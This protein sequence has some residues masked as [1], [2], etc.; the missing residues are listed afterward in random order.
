[1]QI[2]NVEYFVTLAREKH[3]RRAAEACGVSQPTLS[4][5]IGALEAS[6]GIRLVARERRFVGLTPEGEAA[7]PW[8][9]QL[10]ADYDGL[11]R[12][13][14]QPGVGLRGRLRLGA[15]PA[16]MP[17]VGAI[18]PVLA[19]EHPDLRL[20]ILSMNSRQIER[21]LGARDIDG[22]LTYLENEPLSDVISSTFYEEHYHF[23][24]PAAGPF[25][26]R[27]SVTWAEAAI[28]PLCLLT[29]DMQNRRILDAQM[30]RVGVEAA[31]RASANSYA[32]LFS[33]VRHGGLSSILSHVQARAVADDPDIL[34]L[35][36]ADPAPPQ[37]VGLVVPDR[38]PM[39]LKSR[40]ILTCVRS[41]AFRQT[42]NSFRERD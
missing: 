13:G 7:L 25:A 36:F 29:R 12:A 18:A 15:I 14:G 1:M 22:G 32:A 34:V 8:A 31:P 6:L 11:L 9:R 24:T 28:A 35:P 4:A 26:G 5:G 27:E 3:F 39:S 10:L 42:M 2:R 20:I 40:A 33:L 21:E 23:A 19:A 41:P 30:R 17:V 37:A 38:Y 16:A